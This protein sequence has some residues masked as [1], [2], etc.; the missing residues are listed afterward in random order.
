MDTMWEVYL[1]PFQTGRVSEQKLASAMTEAVFISDGEVLYRLIRVQ[2]GRRVFKQLCL[3]GGIPSSVFAKL[4]ARGETDLAFH[5]ACCHS[6]WPFVLQLYDNTQVRAQSRDQAF[7]KALR[8]GV[9]EIVTQMVASDAGSPTQRRTAFCEAIRQEQLQVAYQL[10]SDGGCLNDHDHVFALEACL[11]LRCWETAVYFIKDFSRRDFRANEELILGVVNGSIADGKLSCFLALA[12]EGRMNMMDKQFLSNLFREALKQGREN[13][14]LKF[15]RKCEGFNRFNRFV[16]SA[17]TVATAI[18]VQTSQWSLLR[19]LSLVDSFRLSEYQFLTTMIRTVRHKKAR[20]LCA[21]VLE[22]VLSGS[23]NCDYD[24][25]YLLEMHT[26]KVKSSHAHWCVK[27]A[28]YHLALVLSLMMLN[29]EIATNVVQ[30]I[31]S[32]MKREFLVEALAISCAHSA[33]DLAVALLK[34]MPFD[35]GSCFR[36]RIYCDRNTIRYLSKKCKENGMTQWA[37]YITVASMDWD[38]VKEEMK[39]CHDRTILDFTIGEAANHFRWDL[40]QTLMHRC[41]Q[42]RSALAKPLA[43]AVNNGE[44]QAAKGLIR[45][46]DPRAEHGYC[47]NLLQ[48]AVSSVSNR[49]EMVKLCIEV[50]LSTFEPRLENSNP[51][52][53]Y[54]MLYRSS[55]LKQALNNGQM[56]LVKLLHISGAASNAELV[57]L[58]NDQGLIGQLSRQ[59]RGDIIQ[60]IQDAACTPRS[61]KDLCRLRISHLLGCQPG[62]KERIKSLPVPRLAKD[63]IRFRDILKP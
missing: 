48:L 11:R 13:F 32:T 41:S 5:V 43:L 52:Y 1:R 24:L 50:G 45:K 2:S 54:C 58:K 28:Y 59:G 16:W 27:K 53:T 46:I 6:M 3:K 10:Y 15:C 19:K 34:H 30:K 7:L 36:L 56:P 29:W 25:E 33:F 26:R 49:E 20:K 37:A 51:R 12:E 55:T 62:R 9:W 8:H 39:S 4:E 42:T 63:F 38:L 35:N 47:E 21:P 22:R 44:H 18:S 23:N 17:L 60:Y 61:L 40:V 14:V 57:R 31:G